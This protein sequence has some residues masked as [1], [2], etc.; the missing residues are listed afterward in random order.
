MQSS[1]RSM[2][3]QKKQSEIPPSQGPLSTCTIESQRAGSRSEG[4]GGNGS[5]VKP[6]SQTKKTT[7]PAIKSIQICGNVSPRL[8]AGNG[9]NVDERLRAARERREEQQKLLVSRELSRLEREQRARRYYEQQLQERRKK[10]LEQRLKEE[11]RRAA[12]EE[13]RKQRMREEKERHETTVRKTIERSQK[14]QQHLG[15]SSRG[16]KPT[17]N[18]A[19]V[20]LVGPEKKL[21]MFVAVQFHATH[22]MPS[23]P[24]TSSHPNSDISHFQSPAGRLHHPV[25]ITDSKETSALHR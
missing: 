14:A 8:F 10:L 23:L 3:V 24:L 15:Q 17:K 18:G 13:K 12:V 19:R 21:S 6:S 9:L 4:T 25:P 1:I 7:C 20:Q 5:Y 22:R 11:R 2:A 16:R